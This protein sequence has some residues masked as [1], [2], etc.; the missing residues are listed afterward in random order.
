MSAAIKYS[1][2]EVG[3]EL[4]KI[5]HNYQRQDLVKYAN[6]SVSIGVIGYIVTIAG[7]I[8]SCKRNKIFAIIF[9][10]FSAGICLSSFIIGGKA[11]SDAN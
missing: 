9:L 2:V 4:P 11:I 3:F 1:D 10:L 8:L 6:A 7:F 5:I